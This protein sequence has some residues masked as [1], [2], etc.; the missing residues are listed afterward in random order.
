MEDKEVLE[1]LV[2]FEAFCRKHGVEVWGCGCCDSPVLLF[3]P[4]K[5]DSHYVV[6]KVSHHEGT[7]GWDPEEGRLGDPIEAY[8]L[9]IWTDPKGPKVLPK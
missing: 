7:E 4:W 3:R 6:Q 5:E 1:F 9:D 8:E 2:E